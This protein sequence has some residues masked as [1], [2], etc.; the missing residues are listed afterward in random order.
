[1][2]PGGVPRRGAGESASQTPANQLAG[3]GDDAFLHL[4]PTCGMQ[5]V[6]PPLV[7]IPTMRSCA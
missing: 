4:R 1:M 2:Q 7:E 3:G 6:L 5:I